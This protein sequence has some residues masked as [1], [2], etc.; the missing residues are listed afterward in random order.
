MSVSLKPISQQVIFITGASNGVGLAVVR[1]AIDQG[2]KVFMVDDHEEQLQKIQDEMRLNDRPTA[3]AIADVAEANQLQAAADQCIA[4]FGTIDTWI[5]NAT[6]S[7]YAR[8]LDTNETEARRLFDTNFWGVV[9]GCQVAAAML[10]N[11]GGTI[12]NMGGPWSKKAI[13]I[14]GLY[15][16]SKEAVR[17]F[18][19]SFRDE[20]KE[21]KYPISVSLVLPEDSDRVYLPRIVAENVLSCA[22]VVTKEIGMKKKFKLANFKKLFPKK[23]PAIKISTPALSYFNDFT[24]YIKRKR[25][26]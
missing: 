10:K 19:D 8:I 21:G 26:S 20:L 17:G 5:N 16:A 22:S 24:T 15:C 2:A 6:I 3:F 9:N 23:E 12:I 18:T 25:A 13:P 4:T 11:S 7:L 1:Q 14:Q